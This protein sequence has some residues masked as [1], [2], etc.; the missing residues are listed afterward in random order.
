MVGEN[1]RHSWRAANRKTEVRLTWVQQQREA[2]R[3]GVARGV[4][5]GEGSRGGGWRLAVATRC[6]V[7]QT[8]RP[9]EG[10]AIDQTLHPP[11]LVFLPGRP[12]T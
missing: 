8:A 2:T 4:G 5:G 9:E 3:I 7:T 1:T 12:A 6:T 11:V 10:R